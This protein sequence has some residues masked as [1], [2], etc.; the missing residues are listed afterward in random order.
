MEEDIIYRY[1]TCQ[2]TEEEDKAVLN[3]IKA[4]KENE[5]LFFELKTIWHTYSEQKKR[6]SMVFEAFIEQFKPA[7][8]QCGKTSKQASILQ[9]I[10]VSME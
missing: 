6:R 1:F 5:V 8:R 10:S 2:T 9:E 3:W 4:S 7:H